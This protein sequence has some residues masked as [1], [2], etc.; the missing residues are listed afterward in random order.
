M[1]D[2]QTLEQDRLFIKSWLDTYFDSPHREMLMSSPAKTEEGDYGVPAAMQDGEIDEEGW[3]CWKMLDSEVTEKQINDLV[4]T[5]IHPAAHAVSFSLPSLYTAYLSSRCVLNIYLR[6]DAFTV[7][8]PNL[9]SDAPLREVSGLWSAWKPLI[10][11]GYIP[12]A[13]YEDGAGPV[14][15]DTNQPTEENDYAVVSFDHEVLTVEEQP[16]REKLEQY[17][18]PL[19]PSFREMLISAAS[20]SRS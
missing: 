3:V 15:W 11:A 14:C 7:A 4:Q 16:V 12:F 6:Y 20:S 5:L 13:G 8:L 9:A 1:N 17:A 2:A 10:A 19:F 18:R